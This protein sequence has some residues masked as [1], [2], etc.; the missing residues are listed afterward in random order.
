MTKITPIILAGICLIV[1]V[2]AQQSEQDYSTAQ[3]GVRFA[4]LH[5][6]LDSG[7]SSLAA[8]QFELKAAA[9]QIKIVGVEGGRH[10]AF[11]DAPYYDP[12]ALAKDRIIIAAFSTGS[13]LPKGRT[14]IATIHLQIIG[15]AEPQYEL[16]LTVAADADAKEIPAEITFE[17]GE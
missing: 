3:S 9:G 1:P 13:D 14:R 4:P 16:K 17:K 15:D 10:E 12:A 8:Y 2:L 6:Y 7:N 11:K 5:I